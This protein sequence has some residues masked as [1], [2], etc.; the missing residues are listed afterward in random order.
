MYS[1]FRK[2]KEKKKICVILNSMHALDTLFLLNQCT[3]PFQMLAIPVLELETNV[4]L[5]D[6]NYE[7]N[8][9]CYMKQNWNI[10]WEFFLDPN[11]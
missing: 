4:K 11:T 9:F 5:D 2:G 3:S 8:V 6:M 7:V 1:L 10:I